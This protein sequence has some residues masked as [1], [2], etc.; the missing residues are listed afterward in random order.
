MELSNKLVNL[1][2]YS[3]MNNSKFIIDKIKT[4]FFV[5]HQQATQNLIN[6]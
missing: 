4:T 2:Q 1:F 5:V 6:F 3:L